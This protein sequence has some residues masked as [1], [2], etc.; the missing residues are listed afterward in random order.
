MKQLGTSATHHGTADATSSGGN[1]VTT[2]E[3]AKTGNDQNN[4][5][6]QKHLEQSSNTGDA[7]VPDTFEVAS[8]SDDDSSEA[9]VL[10]RGS[11]NDEEGSVFYSGDDELEARHPSEAHRFA[12]RPTQITKHPNSRQPTTAFGNRHGKSASSWI[13]PTSAGSGEKRKTE[14]NVQSAEAAGKLHS[15]AGTGT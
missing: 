12:N 3:E 1:V 4:Q 8:E 5:H 10:D 7:N 15:I 2:P 6:V 9:E 13:G 11:I 14:S